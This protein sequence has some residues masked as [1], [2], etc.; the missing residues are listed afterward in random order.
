[1]NDIENAEIIINVTLIS[2]ETLYVFASNNSNATYKDSNYIDREA[3]IT[4]DK[5]HIIRIYEKQPQLYLSVEYEKI[6]LTKSDVLIET[7]ML[8]N[9]PKLCNFC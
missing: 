5:I 1:M 6:E 4:Q 2:N 9:C 7:S 8:E 3:M